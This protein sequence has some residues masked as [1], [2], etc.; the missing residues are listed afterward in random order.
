[1]IY[2][3]ELLTSTKSIGPEEYIIPENYLDMLSFVKDRKPEALNSNPSIT[4]KHLSL[5]R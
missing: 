1:M 2:T 4:K 5:A 3:K